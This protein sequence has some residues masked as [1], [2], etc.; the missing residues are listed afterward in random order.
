MAIKFRQPSPR[1]LAPP[2]PPLSPIPP[3]PLPACH[4]GNFVINLLP[5]AASRNCRSSRRVKTIF[6]W[7]ARNVVS[8]LL[9]PSLSRCISALSLSLSVSPPR[10]VGLSV[11]CRAGLPDLIQVRSSSK[12]SERSSAI[13]KLARS[14]CFLSA[15]VSISAL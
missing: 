13:V 15:F 4:V 7:N 12:E 14:K 6:N 3:S 10:C 2:L 8:C 9:L 5:Q 11:V 1:L